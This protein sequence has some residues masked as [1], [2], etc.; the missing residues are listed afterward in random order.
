MVSRIHEKEKPLRSFAPLF[1]EILQWGPW[2]PMRPRDRSGPRSWGHLPA[3]QGAGVSRR[4]LAA[5]EAFGERA[6]RPSAYFIVFPPHPKC[7]VLVFLAHLRP[8]PSPYQ[9]PPLCVPPSPSVSSV[10]LFLPRSPLFLSVPI[11]LPLSFCTQSH[12]KWA[13]VT[14]PPST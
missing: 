12:A 1:G 9:A 2:G 13:I 5:H 8:P 7:E 11:S 6:E 10:S 14:P 3:G 4:S